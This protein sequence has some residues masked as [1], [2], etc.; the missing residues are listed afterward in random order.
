MKGLSFHRFFIVNAT[1][2]SM[3]KQREK[4]SGVT[5]VEKYQKTEYRI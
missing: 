1:A 5:R 3:K 4:M 2:P